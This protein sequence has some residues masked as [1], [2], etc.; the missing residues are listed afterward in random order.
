MS[1]QYI[2]VI[3]LADCAL[4]SLMPAMKIMLKLLRKSLVS[5]MLL[6]DGM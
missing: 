3:A 4:S 6:T 5:L 2:I 1:V